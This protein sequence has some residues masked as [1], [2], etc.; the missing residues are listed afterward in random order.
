MK[1]KR[2]TASDFVINA[3]ETRTA[4]TE[5]LVHVKQSAKS[6]TARGGPSDRSSKPDNRWP[7]APTK[8]YGTPGMACSRYFSCSG[9]TAAT[10]ARI[11]P[12]GAE[13]EL[14]PLPDLLPHLLPLPARPAR[15]ACRIPRW[16]NVAVNRLVPDNAYL[17]GERHVRCLDRGWCAPS[18]RALS[19]ARTSQRAERCVCLF[20]DMRWGR[21]T[22]TSG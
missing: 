14:T 20:A 15:P 7:S 13:G 19:P 4:A 5:C 10:G 17:W 1:S 21:T 11:F 2:R 3:R 18:F 9:P 22:R 12:V 6:A 8:S 16:L